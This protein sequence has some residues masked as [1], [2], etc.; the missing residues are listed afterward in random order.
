MKYQQVS[1]INNLV[2]PVCNSLTNTL[3]YEMDM[4]TR[5]TVKGTLQCDTCEKV[6][7]WAEKLKN[8]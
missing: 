6:D 4:E 3:N 7:E 8:D 2:C 1:S 5:L